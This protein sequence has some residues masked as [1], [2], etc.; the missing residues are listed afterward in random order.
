MLL[1]LELEFPFSSSCG[2]GGLQEEILEVFE[3]RTCL[4]ALVEQHRQCAVGI[5]TDG[6]RQFQAAG[7]VGQGSGGW[8][9]AVKVRRG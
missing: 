4:A 2:L 6:I 5:E 3:P 8:V 1:P 9:C 7:I